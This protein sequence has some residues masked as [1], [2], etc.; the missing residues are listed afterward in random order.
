MNIRGGGMVVVG[1]Y[2]HSGEDCMMITQNHNYDKGNAI[3]Y[4]N[5]NIFKTMETTKIKKTKNKKPG[6]GLPVFKLKE[7]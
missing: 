3:P 5:T 7:D 1:N 6:I 4:D 2:F